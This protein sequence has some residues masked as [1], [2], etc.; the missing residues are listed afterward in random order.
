VGGSVQVPSADFHSV[1]FVGV[2]TLRSWQDNPSDN[3][4]DIEM[5]TWETAR[6]FTRTGGDN[7]DASV[8][9]KRGDEKEQGG[10]EESTKM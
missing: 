3:F 1:E 7:A 2:S 10:E 5:A 8:A 6:D 4:F 9:Q